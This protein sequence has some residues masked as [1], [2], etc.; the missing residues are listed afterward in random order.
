M[1]MICEYC[2]KSLVNIMLMP[3]NYE[4]LDFKKISL[5]NAL[6]QAKCNLPLIFHDSSIML[7]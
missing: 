7:N 1:S 4:R 6:W 5:L 3:S 2:K